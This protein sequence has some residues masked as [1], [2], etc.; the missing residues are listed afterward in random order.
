MMTIMTMTT[1]TLSAGPASFEHRRAARRV[2][3]RPRAA[4][5]VGELN[6]VTDA[7]FGS[8][9]LVTQQFR[10][11]E[12]RSVAWVDGL[13]LRDVCRDPPRRQP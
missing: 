7:H 3:N 9:S 5:A 12:L 1:N 11:G 4:L 10:V 2:V 8:Q 6:N 13:E